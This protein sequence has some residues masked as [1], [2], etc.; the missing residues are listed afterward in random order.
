MY[1]PPTYLVTVV[2]ISAIATVMVLRRLSFVAY[3]VAGGAAVH[4]SGLLLQMLV[5][6]V[7]VTQPGAVVDVG[8]GWQLGT[9]LTELGTIV[10]LC[11]LLW[12]FVRARDLTAA[13]RGGTKT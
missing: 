1:L 4:V 7:D 12:Y 6:P 13:G 5:S 10:F 8:P 2:L 11:G 3:I 9:V